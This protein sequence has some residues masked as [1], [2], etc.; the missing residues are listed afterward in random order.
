MFFRSPEPILL[1]TN[2]KTTLQR[3]DNIFFGLS[4]VNNILKT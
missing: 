2:L 4:D 3:R 1:I